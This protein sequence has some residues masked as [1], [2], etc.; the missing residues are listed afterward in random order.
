MRVGRPVETGGPFD[1]AYTTVVTVQDGRF[2][3]Y[4]EYW[5]PLAVR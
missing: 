1:T 3:S 5:N 2:A 4:R